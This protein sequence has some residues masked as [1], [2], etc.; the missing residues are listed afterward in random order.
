MNP[1]ALIGCTVMLLLLTVLLLTIFDN[2][3]PRA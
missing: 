2:N 1:G 3:D